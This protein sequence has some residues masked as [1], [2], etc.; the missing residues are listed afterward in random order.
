MVAGTRSRPSTKPP[1]PFSPEGAPA[2][3]RY[4]ERRPRC[5]RGR[6]A[7]QWYHRR[8]NAVGVVLVLVEGCRRRRGSGRTRPTRIAPN[9]ARDP[10]ASSASA[11]SES[12]FQPS[13]RAAWLPLARR[14]PAWTQH[15]R[16][17]ARRHPALSRALGALDDVGR[18]GGFRDQRLRAWR[19]GFRR[20]SVALTEPPTRNDHEGPDNI[21][22]GP[23][24][25]A[26][27]FVSPDRVEP[28]FSF[29]PL[30]PVR[31]SSREVKSPWTTPGDELGGSTHRPR[32][33][34]SSSTSPGDEPGP[35]RPSR[36][37]SCAR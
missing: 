18:V 33:P 2:R 7:R 12:A 1:A 20:G 37:R 16:G 35:S 32:R 29:P 22:H 15:A 9:P 36:P 19:D 6:R 13:R 21:L 28:S 30:P 17:S 5:G 11:R 10:T 25:P 26:A 23:D 14:T 4:L 24:G 3:H 8:C 34:A 27:T 31:P